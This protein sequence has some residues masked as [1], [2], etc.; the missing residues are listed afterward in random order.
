MFTLPIHGQGGGQ[1]VDVERATTFR[2]LI[3]EQL[4]DD[5]TRLDD[6]LYLNY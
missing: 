2:K 4:L 5:N 1:T 6:N 3:V